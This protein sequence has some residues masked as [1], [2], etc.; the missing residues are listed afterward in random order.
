MFT[1]IIEGKGTVKGLTKRTSHAL[2]V[3]QSSF[4]LRGTKLGDS[5]ALDGCCLT[6][7]KLKGREFSADISPETLA[8]TTLGK[9]KKGSVVNLERPLRF[10]D[11]LGGHLVQGHVDGVGK[12]LSNRRVPAKPN[13]YHLIQVEVPKALKQYMIQKGSVTVDGISLTVNNVQGRTIELCII[14]HTREKTTLTGKK[15]GA[16]LNIE[17]DMVLKYL[18]NLTKPALK[19]ARKRK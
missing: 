8:R 16:R 1:G 19:N 9:L 2:I 14:P 5:I 4:S 13:S 18:E 17:A 6:V 11:R 12:V 15:R 3:V 10:G 7:T